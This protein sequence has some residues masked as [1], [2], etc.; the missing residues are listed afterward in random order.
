MGDSSLESQVELTDNQ[1]MLQ[2][3]PAC[4]N[5]LSIQQTD[6][7]GMK[8]QCQVCP[9]KYNIIQ[10]ICIREHPSKKKLDDVLGGAD[11]WASVQQTIYESGC[12]K[13][14]NT[15]AYFRVQ[16]TRSADEP[17]TRFYRCTEP[18]CC[19]NWRETE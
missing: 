19:H 14:G 12:E 17:S 5:L 18:K 8:F 4:G 1:K 15:K 11:A 6:T 16:Q 2:F 9:Y 13:C 10:T 3:C 7:I